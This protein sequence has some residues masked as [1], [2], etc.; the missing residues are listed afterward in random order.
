MIRVISL[1]LPSLLLAGCF[2]Q[3]PVP[4]VDR[5][6]ATQS[7]AAAQPA[8]PGY[9][10]VKRGD[11]LYKTGRIG[12]KAVFEGHHPQALTSLQ[13]FA[14]LEQKIG[15]RRFPD[16]GIAV[17]E[18]LVQQDASRGHAAHQ[19]RQQC[20]PE[21]VR[22]DHTVEGLDCAVLRQWPGAVFDIG[23]VGGDPWFSVRGAQV[24]QGIECL[25][26]SVDSHH[27]MAM[28]CEPANVPP[29]PTGHIEHRAS[30]GHQMCPAAYPVGSG[31]RAVGW[32]THRCR[33]LRNIPRPSGQPAP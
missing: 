8:G 1:I 14:G 16:G 11:T 7:R 6:S 23:A 31:R 21:V 4:A 18:G 25:L 24:G 15:S 3:Q 27:R 17:R 9:Y 28:G 30:C 33:T 13:Q 20:A 26:R 12:A 29:V 32:F 2:S 19:G 22:D 5:N 10:T